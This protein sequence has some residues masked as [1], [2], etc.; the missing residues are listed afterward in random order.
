VKLLPQSAQ[1]HPQVMENDGL[2]DPSFK[3]AL[4]TATVALISLQA[5]F[6][7][8]RYRIALL[9]RLVEKES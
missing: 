4:A 3:W 2:K 1:L 5:V 7:M 9:R 6:V 8:L